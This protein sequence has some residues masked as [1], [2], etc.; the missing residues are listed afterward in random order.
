ME[1]LQVIKAVPVEVHSLWKACRSSRTLTSLWCTRLHFTH[2]KESMSSMNRFSILFRE[3]TVLGTFHLSQSSHSPGNQQR[4]GSADFV[5]VLSCAPGCAG[6][7]F[8][9]TRS[10]SFIYF[11]GKNGEIA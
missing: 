11:E 2:G 6:L 1:L 5:A 7:V 10:L 8:V 3:E 9:P 4:K